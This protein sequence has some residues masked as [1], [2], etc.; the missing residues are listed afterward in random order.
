MQ[1]KVELL[2]SSTGP[3][4]FDP[5]TE[6]ILATFKVTPDY[7]YRHEIKQ[8]MEDNDLLLIK[9]YLPWHNTLPSNSPQVEVI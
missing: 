2:T 4:L 7:S 9:R 1:T 5:E 3:Y 6:Q 8:F